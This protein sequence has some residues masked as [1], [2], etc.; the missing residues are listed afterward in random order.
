[1]NKKNKIALLFLSAFVGLGLLFVNYALAIDQAF[2]SEILNQTAESAGYD[3]SG[4]NTLI[5]VIAK[6]IYIFISF[7]GIVFTCLILYGGYLW[8]ADRGNS[9]NIEKA[10]K[11]FTA[12]IIGIIIMFSAYA[13]TWFVVKNLGDETLTEPSSSP[14]GI[15]TSLRK[16]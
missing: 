6:V 4:K 16:I 1:M 8:M 15:E 3:I 7:A 11:L 13:I 10:K 9:E 14:T 5:D 12:A 2:D